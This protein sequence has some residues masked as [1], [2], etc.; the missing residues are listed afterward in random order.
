[1]ILPVEADF[2][3][4]TYAEAVVVLFRPTI[5]YYTFHRFSE[6]KDIAE[7][8]PLSPHPRS[9]HMGKAGGTGHCLAPDVQAMAFQLALQ[10]VRQD[11][12]ILESRSALGLGR[13]RL[14]QKKK[15]PASTAVAECRGNLRARRSL[16]S[17]R[18]L[19]LRH[20]PPR[21]RWAEPAG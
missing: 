11:P 14:R 5:S 13:P 2:E 3:L 7:F 12:I 16:L 18:K 17:V 8:G 9:R 21:S 15:S 4:R 6:S 10:A 19:N 20:G 1:V